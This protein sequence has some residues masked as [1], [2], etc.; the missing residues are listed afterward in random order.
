MLK[1]RAI[2]LSLS[3]ETLFSLKSQQSLSFDFTLDS[4][5]HLQTLLLMTPHGQRIN[6]E[7]KA[8]I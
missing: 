4:A 1:S 6:D 5:E 8:A 7:T 3:L 2:T